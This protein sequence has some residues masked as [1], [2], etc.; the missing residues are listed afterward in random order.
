[1]A[2]KT[3]IVHKRTEAI[4][5][6]GATEDRPALAEHFK[7]SS[8]TKSKAQSRKIN[9]SPLKLLNSIFVVTLLTLFGINSYFVYQF[10]YHGYSPTQSLGGIARTSLSVVDQVWEPEIRQTEN[11]TAGLVMGIDSRML[12]FDGEKFAG[13]DRDIDTIMQVVFNHDTGDTFLFSIPRDTGVTITEECA[14][15]K[16]IYFRSINHAYKLAEDGECQGGGPAIMKKY[17]T[18]ITGFENHYYAIISYQ[19]FRDIVDAVGDEKDG[20]RG[21]YIDV[22]RNIQEYYPIE[23]GNGFEA[24]YFPEGRQFIDSSKLLKYA[25]SR[26]ASN[27][28]DRARR[29]QQVVEAVQAKIMSQETFH[30]P[31]KMYN[32]YKTF[33]DNAL[34]SALSLDDFRA[35]ISLIQ[36][37]DDGEVH[38]FVLDDTFGGKDSL[39]SKPTFSNGLHN[40]PGYY[41]SP[42]H[43]NDPECKSLDDEYCKVKEHIGNI[44]ANPEVYSEQASVFAYV[45][46]SGSSIETTSFLSGERKLNLPLTRSRFAMPAR[47]DLGEIQI[48]DFSNG[49]K[50]KTAQMLE[51][52]FGVE[53][54]NG[55]SAPFNS[56]LNKEDFAIIVKT[57]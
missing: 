2:I 36:Q 5:T 20:K 47:A 21:V 25:R 50:P 8:K 51:N 38:K 11:Y 55:Q 49:T 23:N 35:G 48:Y 1:M 41:L 16:S 18:S 27:D 42:V 33:T 32:L 54:Y 4:E 31:I 52:A 26:K 56:P 12:E 53:V 7:K 19:A 39:L 13:R 30:D 40:R 34:F 6:A 10:E 43:Y 57:N 22:P 3:R 24:V 9:L 14:D 17:V 45:N 15:Q 44:F 29:Q 28:F 46:I 37:L